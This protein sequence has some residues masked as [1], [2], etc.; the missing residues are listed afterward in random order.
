VP[1][2]R[3]RRLALKE[4]VDNALD[5]GGQVTLRQPQPGHYVIKDDGPG[6]DGSPEQVARLFSID[7][8]LVSSKLWR[9]PLRGALG[10]G[11]RVVA[12]AIIASGG[13]S[14]TV[15]T[16]NQRVAIMPLE[17]GGAAVTAEE[18]DFPIGTRIEISFGPLLPEDHAGLGWARAAIEMAG[19]D[20]GYAGKS[21]AHWFDAD[22]FYELV[23]CSGSRL[24]RDLIANLD[25][26]SGGKAGEV[27]SAFLG[28]SC[29]SLTRAETTMLLELAQDM[30]TPPA[31]KRLGAVGKIDSLPAHYAREEG[32]VTLG[33]RVPK[34]QIPFIVEAW[35]D[36][37]Q[38]DEEVETIIDVC[39]NCTPITGEVNISPSGGK[40]VIFGCGLH[41][42]LDVPTQKG[43]WGLT[44]NIT[45]PYV[46]I[47]TEGK[48][49]DLARF[50]DAILAALSGAIKRAH[51]N[52][53][54]KRSISQK[55]AVIANLDEAIAKTSGDGQYRFEQRQLLYALRPIIMREMGEELKTSN[56]NGIITNYEAEH[57]E[58]AGM[59]RDNR[60]ALYHPHMDEGDIPV[61]T[62]M[63]ENYNRPLWTF[64]KIVYIE[65]QGFFE[66]LKAER[67]PECHD[68]ALLT[69]KGFT[70]RA[71]K[72]LIDHLAAHDEP[73]QVFCAHDADA[74]GTMIYQTLQNATPARARRLIEVINFGLEPWEAR[75][76]GLE[77]EAF[78]KKEKHRRAVADY[79]LERLD[80]DHWDEW[81]QSNRYELNAMTTPQFL[82]WITA[83]IEA[84]GAGKLVPP[85]E[86]IA[87]EADKRLEAELRKRITERVLREARIDDQVA[88][89]C[90]RITLPRKHLTRAAIGKWLAKNRLESWRDCIDERVIK[91]FGGREF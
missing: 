7:R 63:V 58:I 89:A 33:A 13:G 27:A 16:R 84:H 62:L 40:L 77:V 15:T 53:P 66:T 11:L 71:V 25:G 42:Y 12:G 76:M 3:L 82:G 45:A 6:I 54:K 29:A 17:D 49:P 2:A 57:G 56:F 64:D 44:L 35:A 91:P 30:T 65:K 23:H 80:G 52:L 5:A 22:A 79:V 41:H 61:G 69:S 67:W 72:D 86:V 32:N 83:K 47:T 39:V 34:A 28:R 19:Y 88:A 74:A 21:S 87:D 70:T 59:Y 73:V 38:N 10:S 51:R 50:K 20:A 60:G 18:A 1:I 55:D 37:L 68:C 90:A 78:E 75:D 85:E 46:P 4:L 81:L 26:C 48:E 14:L 8:G 36:A 43:K 31:I 9:K 24:V